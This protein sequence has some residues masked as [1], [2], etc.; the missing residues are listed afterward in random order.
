MPLTEMVGSD[1]A[2]QEQHGGQFDPNDIRTKERYAHLLGFYNRPASLWAP[3][4]G[5][6]VEHLDEQYCRQHRRTDPHAG[7][8]PLALLG[9]RLCSQVE[10]HDDEHE[11]HHNGPGIDDDFERGDERRAEDE[12]DHG[13]GQERDDQVQERVYGMQ[14]GDHHHRGGNGNCRR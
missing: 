9:R 5:Q 8:Q 4:L 1:Q 7:V 13:D 3:R 11:Q 6:H 12:K 10:H 14:P 2:S